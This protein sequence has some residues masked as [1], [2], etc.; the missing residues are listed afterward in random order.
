MCVCVCVWCERNIM[1]NTICKVLYIFLVVGYFVKCGVLIILC[2]I[3]RYINDLSS[4]SS[5]VLGGTDVK[6]SRRYF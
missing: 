6:E 5:S 4:S 2:E 3:L 1:Y